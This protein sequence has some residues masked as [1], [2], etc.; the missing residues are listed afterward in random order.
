MAFTFATISMD[1]NCQK[2]KFRHPDTDKVVT[3]TTAE[4]D[5]D[6]SLRSAILTTA[7]TASPVSSIHKDNYTLS[8]NVVQASGGGNYAG[9]GDPGY[10]ETTV[11][12]RLTKAGA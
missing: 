4:L 7:L 8:S 12:Q 2:V 1:W 11:Y 3:M 5:A 10:D 6:T 9:V